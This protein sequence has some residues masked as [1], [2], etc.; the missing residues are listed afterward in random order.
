MKGG[1]NGSKILTPFQQNNAMPCTKV[2]R[3]I[4]FVQ[5]SYYGLREPVTNDQCMG[6]KNAYG[7][8][9]SWITSPWVRHNVLNYNINGDDANVIVRKCMK[10]Y[11]ALKLEMSRYVKV[12]HRFQTMN[13]RQ[14]A[15]SRLVLSHDLF[16]SRNPFIS[17]YK[18]NLAQWYHAFWDH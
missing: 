11:N 18:R 17:C 4:K 14:Y 15:D 7:I 12:L 5:I 16:K 10:N 13:D 8:I 3:L 1:C 9:P 6:L 2:L